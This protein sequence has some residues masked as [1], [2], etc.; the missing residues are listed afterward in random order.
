MSDRMWF[1]DDR[2]FWVKSAGSASRGMHSAIVNPHITFT[3]TNSLLD[4]INLMSYKIGNEDKR[5]LIVVDKDLRKYAEQIADV[6][7]NKKRIDC[8][9]F[10]NVLPDAPKSTVMEGV[11]I[12]SD[13]QPKAIVAIGGGSALDTAK[14]I[15]LLY[16]QPKVNLNY[17]IPA[18]LL[19]L[20]EKIKF[21]VAIPT[22]SGTG[23]EVSFNCVMLDDERNPPKKI[24]VTSYELCPDYVVL[25][26][27]FVQSMPKFLTMGT[28]MDAFAHAAGA[29]VLTMSNE[30]TDMHNLKAIELILKYLPRAVKRGD[31]MESRRKMQLAAYIA[32]TGF[33]NVSA[34]IEHSLGH[35]FG[36]LFHVHH[37][38]SVGLFICASIAYQSKITNRF[39]DIAK[40]FEIETENRK[41]D[42]ILRG[43][44]EGI[45][46]F[47]RSVECPTSIAELKRPE[48]NREDYISK[49]DIMSD[50][51][52]LDVPTLFSSR[53]LDKRQIKRLFR[54]SYD[55]KVDDL[56]ELFYK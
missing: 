12:C 20:R 32:G 42:E 1:E 37:G 19:G 26:E 43:L 34:G 11:Q 47:M 5:V 44:L 13:F 10:D 46:D 54:I 39:I 27:P 36:G 49:L 4:F 24:S 17:L 29:Y 14:L 56:M 30:Y 38:V 2:E 35:S 48:I 18:V 25:Y 55:N 33:I 28:G 22:T 9:I 52:Y 45:Q 40:L 15:F 7:V 53:G 6:L 31:D 51:A 41:R 3:G 8:K 16:E 21:L 50:Y 23:A